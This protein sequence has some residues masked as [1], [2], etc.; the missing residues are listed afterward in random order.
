[1]AE[2][3][4]FAAITDPWEST[5]DHSLEWFDET[6]AADPVGDIEYFEGRSMSGD[7]YSL[8]PSKAR[9]PPR[10]YRHI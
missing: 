4:G 8:T 9:T 10:P 3:N 1:M 2:A 6:I 7:R 5:R